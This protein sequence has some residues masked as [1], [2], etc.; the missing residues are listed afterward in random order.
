MESNLKDIF[1]GKT[2]FVH[3]KDKNF[4]VGKIISENEHF[5]ILQTQGNGVMAIPKNEVLNI[6]LEQKDGGWK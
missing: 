3:R 1:Q 4:K 6:E 5:I 2:V